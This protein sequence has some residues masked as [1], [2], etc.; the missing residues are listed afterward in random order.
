MGLGK[1]VQTLAWLLH[2]Q[3]VRSP[4]E[5]NPFRALVVCPKS[6]THGWLVEC[7]RFTPDLTAASFD[8]LRLGSGSAQSGSHLLVANYSQLRLNA[9]WFQ[10]QHWD[11]V[12]LDEGQ[13]IKNPGSQ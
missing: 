13:F 12:I 9:P 6:V 2:L 5:K 7:G 3:S 10:G 8:P 1:T 11:A 4:D